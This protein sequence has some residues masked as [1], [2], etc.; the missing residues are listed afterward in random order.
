MVEIKNSGETALCFERVVD[1]LDKPEPRDET[2]FHVS[3]L[4]NEAARMNDWRD[5][6]NKTKCQWYDPLSPKV[7]AFT[8]LANMGRVVEYM[9]RPIIHE[10]VGMGDLTFNPQVNAYK[11]GIIGTL[12]GIIYRD[13]EDEPLAIVEMKSRWAKPH[14]PRTNLKWMSQV[15]AYL[16]MQENEC[17]TAW[18]PIMFLPRPTEDS[19][20]VTHIQTFLYK[21]EASMDEQKANWNLLLNARAAL[22]AQYIRE[23]EEEI[24]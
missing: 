1:Y 17:T 22:L 14:D 21:L 16:Y 6:L 24:A 4:V 23:G 5:P 15:M 3:S 8:S 7:P 9:F 10:L 12:D 11:D 13:N 19:N 18:M 2:Q 20:W